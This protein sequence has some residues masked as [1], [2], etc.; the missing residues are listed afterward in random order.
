[1]D[2]ARSLYGT[3]YQGEALDAGT[4]FKITPQKGLH[5]TAFEICWRTSDV[6]YHYTRWPAFKA[7]NRPIT[8]VI[9]PHSQL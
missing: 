9:F 1:M 6:H 4:V 3:T 8:S 2:S 5:L 7:C